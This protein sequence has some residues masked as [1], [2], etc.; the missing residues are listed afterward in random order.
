MSLSPVEGES[1]ARLP[2]ARPSI[3]PDEFAAV[4]TTLQSG[5]LG[6]GP[7]VS[8]FEQLV[9]ARVDAAEVV[10]TSSGTAALW[11]SLAALGVGSGDEVLLPSF[12]YSAT[13]QAV[14]AV[15]ATPV[16]CEVDPETAF[17]D[18]DDA[19]RRVTGR[20]V[21]VVPVYY[22]G[23]ASGADRVAAF[24]ERLGLH[25]VEDAA[26]A[27][28]SMRPGGAPVGSGAG[29]SCFSFGPIKPLTC[30][31]GG[32]IALDDVGLAEDLR[33]RCDLGV[34][35]SGSVPRTV[36]AGTRDRMTN[37]G[38][39]LGTAQLKRFDAL[40]DRRRGL[41]ERYATGLSGLSDVTVL[42]HEPAAMV[43][44]LFAVRL[45]CDRRDSLRE[46]LHQR[47]IETGVHYPPNHLE[48]LFD[49]PD[50]SELGVTE[51]LA[52]EIVTLPFWADMLP[53][54]VDRV[55]AAIG[56]VEGAG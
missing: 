7:L 20:T 3:G 53:S 36:Q 17:I 41:W 39:S 18:L 28:G 6:P 43:P 29:L 56:A 15:G 2:L 25:L 50:R 44:F 1:S 8:R 40:A 23:D 22:G 32:A 48:P 42:R 47:G 34:D 24:S 13:A 52:N 10:A 33:R 54:D 5:A 35:R 31:Q 46:S 12:T 51:R 55:V 45:P 16:F 49:S 4:Q 11:L 14:L 38:A 27:F 30:G 9:A 21:A 19:G 37:L 26:H